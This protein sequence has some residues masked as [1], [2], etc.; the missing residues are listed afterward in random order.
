MIPYSEY[1]AT[2]GKTIH[3]LRAEKGLSLRSFSLM[4]GVHYNQVLHIEQ[5]KVNPSLKTL[6]KIAEGLEVEIKDL[7]PEKSNN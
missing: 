6:Y 3:A 2:I 1:I 5:G 4:I 7:L